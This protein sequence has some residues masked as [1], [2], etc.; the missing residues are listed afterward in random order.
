ADGNVALRGSF[1]IDKSGIVRHQVVNDLP[2][3][4]NIDE[5]IRM[6]DA[7][8][9]NEEHG[10]VC[11]AGWKDG[12]AGMKDTPEGVANYLTDHSQSL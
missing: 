7:L 9:F 1:L 12:D 10:E 11:P 2:L 3:G 4:R 5:M 8:Q 6:V